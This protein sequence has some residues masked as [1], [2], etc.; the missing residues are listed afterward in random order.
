MTEKKKRKVH[1]PEYKAKVGLEALKGVKTIN[2][3]GQEYGVHPVQVG[4]W[5]NWVSWAKSSN[6]V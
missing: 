6:A 5:K 4:Q 1:S 2:E 3:I